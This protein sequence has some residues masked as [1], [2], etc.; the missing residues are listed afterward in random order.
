M[1]FET[2]PE[3]NHKSTA[4]IYLYAE[5]CTVEW[6]Y[7]FY[8]DLKDQTCLRCAR[9]TGFMLLSCAISPPQLDC[10]LGKKI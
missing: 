3:T 6:D 7:F 1:Q 4:C 8:L 2:W 5:L 10:V 9:C